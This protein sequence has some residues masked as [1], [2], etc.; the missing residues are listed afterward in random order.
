MNPLSLFAVIIWV[1]GYIIS[2]ASLR[3]KPN[4]KAYIGRPWQFALGMVLFLGGVGIT[5]A[6]I[7]SGKA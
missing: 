5:V 4:G 2:A 7:L 6:L 1:I 3:H